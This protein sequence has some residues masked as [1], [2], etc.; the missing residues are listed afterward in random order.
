MANTNG[1]MN[2]G[3]GTRPTT[4]GIVDNIGG[5]ERFD[6]GRSRAGGESTSPAPHERMN[7][8]R[9]NVASTREDDSAA[10]GLRP[11]LKPTPNGEGEKP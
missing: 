11:N 8:K 5:G 1:I 7:D 10:F 2:S 6:A 3:D 4:D 9:S